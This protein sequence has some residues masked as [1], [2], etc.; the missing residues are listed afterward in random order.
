MVPLGMLTK[1]W[2]HGCEC[3]WIGS[4]ENLEETID[5]AMNLWLNGDLRW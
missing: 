2:N 4:R 5:F 1:N 3:Q